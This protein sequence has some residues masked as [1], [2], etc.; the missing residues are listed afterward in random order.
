MIPAGPGPG[1]LPLSRT[2]HNFNGH[3]LEL[4]KSVLP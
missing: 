1:A 3:R 4:G 2:S